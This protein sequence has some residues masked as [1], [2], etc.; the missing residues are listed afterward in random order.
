MTG[1]QSSSARIYSSRNFQRWAR[2][3][4][5]LRGA[6]TQ[7]GGMH[8]NRL[9]SAFPVCM[10]DTRA[11]EQGIAAV[12]IAKMSHFLGQKMSRPASL[13]SISL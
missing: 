1:A 9:Q 5:E 4:C 12:S 11:V 3:L 7:H 10:D 13:V 6:L 2:P 8:I